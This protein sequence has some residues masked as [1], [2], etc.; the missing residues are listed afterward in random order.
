M[1]AAGIEHHSLGALNNR[2]FLLTVLE[3]GMSQI[4][5]LANPVSGGD[6]LPVSSMAI[7]SLSS[8]GRR[9]QELSRVSFIRALIAFKGFHIYY[10]IVSPPSNAI[11]FGIGFQHKNTGRGTHKRSVHSTEHQCSCP[12]HGDK[13]FY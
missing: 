3:A 1:Q 12:H 13:D 9:T 11:I 4:R 8:Y 7:F 10:L 5:V 6:L 2:N